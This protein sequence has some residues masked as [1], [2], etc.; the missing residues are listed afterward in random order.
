MDYLAYIAGI[1]PND[2]GFAV[3]HTA[4][5]CMIV[6]RTG[7]GSFPA[8]WPP[9]FGGT[10]IGEWRPAASGPWTFSWLPDVT[11]FTMRSGDQFRPGPPPAL[12]SPEYTRVY[13]EVKSLGRSTNSS[14]TVEQTDLA[15]F[16]NG[17][18][19]AQMNK[20]A[21]DLALSHS[22][23]TSE[24]S[25][26]LALVDAA[27]ADSGIAAWDAKRHY[28]FWRPQ[29]AI[30][31]GDADG[32]P[33]TEGDMT[34]TPFIATPP[35]S[36]HSS[37][38]NSFVASATR[39][40]ALYFDTDEMEFQIATTNPG[41]TMTDLRSYS[42]LSQVRDEVVE[43]RI[44]EGIHFRSADADARRQSEHIAQWANSHYFRPVD[45][46]MGAA[47]AAQDPDVIKLFL[48]GM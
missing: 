45:G 17:N 6:L 29:S 35:Y 13:N 28:N 32:N 30:Q 19:P 46:T 34:W 14:R 4:A 40:I 43:A 39:A 33:K 25:K 1:D 47:E 5:Q 16:W 10:G 27:M 41:P 23:S 12:T 8:N 3:G 2:A 18:F 11:P 37:G 20:L 31:N 42:K 22:L 26:L 48:K 9:Y 44:L 24:T 21:R 15:N 7:D 36:D 38:A